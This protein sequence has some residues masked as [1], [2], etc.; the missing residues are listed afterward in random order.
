MR[1][2][3]LS[4]AFLGLIVGTAIGQDQP[5]FTEGHTYGLSP[6]KVVQV[7]KDGL[8]LYV[9]HID[10]SPGVVSVYA[11]EPTVVLL[12][13]YPDEVVDDEAIKYCAAKYTGT[14]SYETASGSTKTVRSFKF[15]RKGM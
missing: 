7:V 4:L 15:V 8:L 5:K 14:V 2:T 11:Q 3:I 13:G 6:I 9:E 12:T 1:T 10:Q